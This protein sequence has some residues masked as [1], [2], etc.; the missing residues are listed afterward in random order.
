MKKKLIGFVII[1][2]LVAVGAFG[3][4]GYRL[5]TTGFSAKTEPHILEVMVLNRPSNSMRGT[6]A[7]NAALVAVSATMTL[8]S[9]ESKYSARPSRDHK[10]Q[11][12]PPVDTC[13]RAPGPGKGWTY[14]SSRP[15]SVD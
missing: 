5:F 14:T 1:L 7:E 9:S 15:E 11:L 4:V 13:L 2:I 8:L 10:G 12:P 3:W 6:L